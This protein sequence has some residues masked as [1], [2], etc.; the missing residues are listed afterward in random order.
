MYFLFETG[1]AKLSLIGPVKVVT[2]QITEQPPQTI[3]IINQ[4]SKK[5]D[6]RAQCL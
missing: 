1:S 2:N 6:S 5:Q 3:E 4:G